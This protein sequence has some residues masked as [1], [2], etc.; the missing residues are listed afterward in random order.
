[1]PFQWHS[2][3]NY[4]PN[5]G[6][7]NTPAAGASV[8]EVAPSLFRDDTASSETARSAIAFASE[9]AACRGGHPRMLFG[10]LRG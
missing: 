2:P 10:E 4:G 6:I 7:V 8:F 1:M 9:M 3:I 5:G